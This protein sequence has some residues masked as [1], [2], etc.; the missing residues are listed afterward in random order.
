VER[1]DAAYRDGRRPGWDTGR[2]SSELKK[3]VED[4][5][6]RAC[7]AV[8]LGCGTGTN[9]IYLAGKGF[10]VTG[11][12]IA[13]TALAHA[14]QKAR[15]AGVRV[16]WMVADVLAPP[17]LEPFDLIYD[18]G[19]YHGVRRQSAAGYVEAVRRL[20][21]PGTRLLILAGNAN[22]PR[23]YGPPRIKEEEIRADFS[24]RFEFEWLR[25]TKFDTRDA[26]SSGALAW[27]ILLRRKEEP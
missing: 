22:E 16:R 21:R 19:C 6:I 26:A 7:R 20:S 1:W 12:D 5:T 8:V 2:P 14:E 25:E 15:K 23:R 3:A 24:A 17:A 18:R 9:A 4:G 27:S 13:P 11:I 10:D